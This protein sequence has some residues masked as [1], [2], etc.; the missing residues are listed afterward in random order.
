[1]GSHGTT[2]FQATLFADPADPSTGA[3]RT[4]VTDTAVSYFNSL[5]VSNNKMLVG[6]PFYGRG[7]TGVAPGANGD[8]LYSTATGPAPGRYEAG[9]NDYK[10]LSTRTGTRKVHPVT[11]QLYLYTGANGEWWSYDDAAAITVKVNYVKSKGL[12][13]VFAWAADGDDASGTLTNAMGA[14]RQ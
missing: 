6:L 12:R 5:G 3:A 13:G 7:W 10:V 11:K 1:L 14:I 2:N 4:Y 8:G 9:I